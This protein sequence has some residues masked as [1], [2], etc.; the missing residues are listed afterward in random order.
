MRLST[1]RILTTHVGSLPRPDD[2]REMLEAN[3][4]QGVDDRTWE[5]HFRAG[6]Y[7]AWFRRVIK[8]DDLA[9][10]AAEVEVDLSLDASE[11]RRRIADAITRRYTAPAEAFVPDF[12]SG[13]S[14]G[15]W[16]SAC[17]LRGSVWRG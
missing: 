4:A 8:N 3:I 10:E 6:D 14:A 9:R 13:R 15:I 2:V 12:W 17:A 5:H 11:S 16:S 7:S 1:E